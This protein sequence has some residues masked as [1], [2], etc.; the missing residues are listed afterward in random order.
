MIFQWPELRAL[1]ARNGATARDQLV[2]L[3][4]RHQDATGMHVVAVFDGKGARANEASEPAG[5]QVFYS[6]AGQTADSVIERIVA[7]YAAQYEIV[8]ATDDNL[9]R[10]TV[11]SF[12]GTWMSSEILA[13]EMRDADS[14]LDDR[15]KR[16]RR[17]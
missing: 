9:E 1:H 15:I 2:R 7:T 17:R 6:K 13:L 3:L 5:I 16:L 8:V 11:E 10:T 4:T 12:G 14:E